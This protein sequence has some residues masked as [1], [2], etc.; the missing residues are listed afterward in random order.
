MEQHVEWTS[1]APFWLGPLDPSS[2]VSRRRFR[3][4]AILRFASDS[5]M[6]DFLNLLQQDP[7]AVPSL[8]A[9]PEDWRGP[10]ALPQ[11]AQPKKGLAGRL[12]RLRNAAERKIEARALAA[13]GTASPPAAAKPLKLYQPA[14]QRYYI[15]CACLVCRTPGLPDLRVDTARQERVSFVVRRLKP[16]PGSTVATCTVDACDEYA[17]VP[18]P[19]GNTWQKAPPDAVADGEELLPLSPAAYIDVNGRKRRLLAGLAPTGKREAYY[20]AAA[21]PSPSPQPPLPSWSNPLDIRQTLLKSDVTEPWA[22][23]LRLATESN[24]TILA[25]L[26]EGESVSLFR[27]T[28]AAQIQTSSWY[29]LLDFAKYLEAWLRPVY[30]ALPAGSPTSGLTQPERDLLTLFDNVTYTRGSTTRSLRAALRDI[31]DYPGLETTTGR[32]AVRADGTIPAPWPQFHFPVAGL[33]LTLTTIDNFAALPAG[34]EGLEEAVVA[35]LDSRPTP[36]LPPPRIAGQAAMNAA[37]SGGDDF[38]I[39]RCVYEKPACGPLAKAVLSEA[40]EPFRIAGFFDP[41][42]PA[43]PIRIALPVDTTPAG[44]R[45]FDKNTMFVMSDILCG[46]MTKLNSLSLGDL[47]LSVLPWPFHKDLDVSMPGP[48]GAPAGP[49]FGMVCSMSIPIITICALILLMIIVKLLDIIFFWIP[50]FRVCL[51]VPGLRGKE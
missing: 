27:D 43:R 33:R 22:A 37:N 47:V 8:K 25:G 10:A 35:A 9:A 28:I 36:A 11:L 15:V 48:C 18:G 19:A 2:G 39:V 16:P 20:A 44:L 29:L 31:Q 41:D 51:P 6:E 24:A 46:Q 38:F 26:L 32:Y 14:H 17:F 23:L 42:A 40:S 34:V 12:E 21:A 13:A 4:P 7:G 3:R 1:P 50:F 45:K 49:G 5:F 30:E